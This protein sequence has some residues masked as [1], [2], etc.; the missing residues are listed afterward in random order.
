MSPTMKLVWSVVALVL[1][2]FVFLVPLI[3]GS[4]RREQEP[5]WRASRTDSSLRLESPLV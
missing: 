4:M 3:P 1:V 2:V 5:Y